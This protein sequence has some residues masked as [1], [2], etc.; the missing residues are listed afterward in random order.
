MSDHGAKKRAILALV[1]RE[2]DLSHS[3]IAQR[4]GCSREYVALMLGRVGRA[5]KIAERNRLMRE[6]ADGTSTLK[7]IAARFGV[8]LSSATQVLRGLPRAR[9]LVHGTIQGYRRGCRCDQCEPALRKAYATHQQ[10]R[11]GMEPPRHG[12]NGYVNYGCRCPTCTAANSTA[13]RAYYD[14]ARAQRE[15]SA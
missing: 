10:R 2:R 1:A 5:G 6:A 14:R 11:K 7:E 9:K 13:G 12:R 3:E 4:V 15:A 8:S